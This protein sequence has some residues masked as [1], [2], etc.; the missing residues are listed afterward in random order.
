MSRCIDSNRNFYQRVLSCSHARRGPYVG[1]RCRRS[2]RRSLAQHSWSL[3]VALDR[4]LLAVLM[5]STAGRRPEPRP[6]AS[7]PPFRGRGRDNANS[8]FAY[9]IK[10]NLIHAYYVT[11]RTNIKLVPK[12]KLLV[13]TRQIKT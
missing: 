11:T 4:C 6:P 8:T 5:G 13:M 7:S 9:I 3:V 10:R 1:C 2:Q 12:L